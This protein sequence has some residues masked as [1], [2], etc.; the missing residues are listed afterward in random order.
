MQS[1]WLFDI[2]IHTINPQIDVFYIIA[3]AYVS[4]CLLL[5]GLTFNDLIRLSCLYITFLTT[6]SSLYWG[7][8]W[9]TSLGWEGVLQGVP[10][11]MP[12]LEVTVG[13]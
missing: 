10:W 8:E 2:K 5:L 11:G 3:C 13:L 6:G 7:L 4:P 12:G 9:L 1:H